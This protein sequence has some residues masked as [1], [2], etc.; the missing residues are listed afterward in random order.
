MET[1]AHHALVGFFVVL[2]TLAGAFFSLW[3]AQFSFD[4]E[5]A[6]YDIVFEGAVRG[7]RTSSEVHFNGIQVGEVTE[8]GLNPQNTSEVIARVRVDATTPVRADSAARLEPQGLTGLSYIQ[9]TP[10][11]PE[12]PLLESRPGDRPARIY[13]QQTQLDQLLAGGESLLESITTTTVSINRLLSDDNVDNFSDL[14]A[15]IT[16]LSDQLAAQETMAADIRAAVVSI[17]QAAQDIGRAAAGLEEFGTSAQAF[18]DG[19][20]AEMVREVDASAAEV[21]VAASEAAAMIQQ[22]RPSIEAFADD[23]LGQLTAATSD[24]RSLAETL[25]R[26]ALSLESD[27]AGF[28]TRPRGEEVEVPQ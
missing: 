10:G 2:L 16:T 17:D 15:N 23:G 5:Y 1:K 26:I 21:N 11:S 18:L 6:H 4:R 9:I 13:G 12:S 28:V 22:I 19:E 7:L 8:L 14:L 20:V 24:I 27:P 25:E 3:L